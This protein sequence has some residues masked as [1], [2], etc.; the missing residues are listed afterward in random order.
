MN[1]R[2]KNKWLKQQI[3]SLKSDNHLMRQIIADSPTMQELYDV[4]T[5][6]VQVTYTTMQIQEYRAKRRIPP[7]KGSNEIIELEKHALAMD[8]FREIEDDAITYT[9]DTMDMPLTIT[10]SIFIGIK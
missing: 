7:F 9:F 6:P 8:L 1:T 3:K 10:A 5:K 2:Q 4:Y